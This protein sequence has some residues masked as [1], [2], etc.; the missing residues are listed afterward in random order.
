M[1]HVLRNVGLLIV[2]Y[3]SLCPYVVLKTQCTCAPFPTGAVL[4]RNTAVA[5][6]DIGKGQTFSVMGMVMSKSGIL[7]FEGTF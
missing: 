5:V 7:R 4:G 1:Q 6:K 2:Q 3:D